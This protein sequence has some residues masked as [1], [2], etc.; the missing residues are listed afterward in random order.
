MAM[1]FQVT[2]ILFVTCFLITFARVRENIPSIDAVTTEVNDNEMFK[3]SLMNELKFIKSYCMDLEEKMKEL[4]LNNEEKSKRIE[5]LES[6]LETMESE[7]R[8]SKRQVGSNIA[9]TVYSDHG[10]HNLSHDQPIIYNKASLR[11]FV[12]L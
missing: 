4:Q 2:T 10:V 5:K 6:R 7:G 1:H 8:R 11:G 12:I 9:F 3:R